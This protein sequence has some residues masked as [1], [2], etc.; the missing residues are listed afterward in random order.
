MGGHLTG[1]L[2]NDWE[3]TFS[4][5]PHY[6]FK[7][8]QCEQSEPRDSMYLQ[9]SPFADKVVSYGK[10]VHFNKQALA[11]EQDRLCGEVVTA[12]LVHTTE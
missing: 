11:A 6:K 5:A 9:G 7:H 1:L 2:R 3:G 10:R 4:D 8:H 12:Q